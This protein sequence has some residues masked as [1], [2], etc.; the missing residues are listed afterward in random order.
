MEV[1]SKLDDVS[2]KFRRLCKSS[3]RL[4]MVKNLLDFFNVSIRTKSLEGIEPWH[5]YIVSQNE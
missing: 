3:E 4:I 1:K 2:N 5:K